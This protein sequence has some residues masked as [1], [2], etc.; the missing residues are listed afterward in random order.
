MTNEENFI[1]CKTNSNWFANGWQVYRRGDGAFHHFGDWLMDKEHIKVEIPLVEVG[2]EWMDL[3]Q[4]HKPTLFEKFKALFGVHYPEID[5][6]RPNRFALVVVDYDGLIEVAEASPNK[7][8]SACTWITELNSYMI[9]KRWAYIPD[10][11][12]NNN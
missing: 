5:Y 6:V 11:V 8:G 1:L 2:L 12:L 10:N 9:P 3:K 4:P 7:D